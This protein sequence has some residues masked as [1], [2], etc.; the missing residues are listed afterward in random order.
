[1]NITI[2]GSNLQKLTFPKACFRCGITEQLDSL[3]VLETNFFARASSKPFSIF[4]LVLLFS[5]GGFCLLL[6]QITGLDLIWL[7]LLVYV[8]LHGIL[9]Q[10]FWRSCKSVDLPYCSRC[11]RGMKARHIIGTVFGTGFVAAITATMF[12]QTRT[13]SRYGYPGWL[14]SVG[15]LCFIFILWG[16]FDAYNPKIGMRKKGSITSIDITDSETGRQMLELNKEI[17]LPASETGS[18]Q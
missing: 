4:S 16:K 8:C 9:Q 15:I 14:G 1:M 17:I 5:A 18:S 2:N 6:S 11:I 12:L 13:G 7:L 10:A 3:K